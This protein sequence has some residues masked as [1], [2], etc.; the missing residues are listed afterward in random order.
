LILL[1]HPDSD[2]QL[3]RPVDNER[4]PAKERPPDR[5]DV[6]LPLLQNSLRLLSRRD[7]PNSADERGRRSV[8]LSVGMDGLADFGGE[9]N[10]VQWVGGNGL[11]G[12][13]SAA[14]D[15][16]EVDADSNRFADEDLFE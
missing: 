4:R 16:D 7:E 6:R 2:A 5:N 3:L 13:V 12:G 15:V 8:L 10:L 9:G 14:G 11:V 1:A